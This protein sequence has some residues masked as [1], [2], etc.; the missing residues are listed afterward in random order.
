MPPG[1]AG[2]H[3]VHPR[4]DTVMRSP[5]L[6]YF[7]VFLKIGIFQPL[8]ALAGS[9]TS[10]DRHTVTKEALH[11]PPYRPPLISSGEPPISITLPSQSLL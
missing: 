9:V 8:P 11:A 10:E 3:E 7:P 6:K 5:T 1:P 4:A 2:K